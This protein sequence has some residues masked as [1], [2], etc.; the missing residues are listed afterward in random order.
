MKK[1]I[2]LTN[3]RFGYLIVEEFIERKNGNT[4]WRCKC[5]CGKQTVTTTCRLRNGET[6]SCGCYYKNG[7]YRIKL[8]DSERRLHRIYK[9][10]LSRCY[11]NNNPSFKNYGERGIKVCDEWKNSIDNFVS[12]ALNNGYKDDLTIDRIDNDKSYKPDNCRWV[13]QKEQNNNTRRNV[14]IQ[15]EGEKK[16]ISQW[17]ETLDI[18][19][20]ALR[21]RLKKMSTKDAL[22][23]N[24][25]R[26]KKCVRV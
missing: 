13:T 14:Y 20:E 5:D 26:K 1:I 9:A 4:W 11:K 19:S 17:A 6:K 21:A 12:W 23:T 16:T 24:R 25:M 18:T 22:K 2:D 10:M 15:F 8:T 3:Q 7:K